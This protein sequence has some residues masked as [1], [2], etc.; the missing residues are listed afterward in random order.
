[1]MTPPQCKLWSFIFFYFL[2]SLL[3]AFYVSFP[4][5]REF[6]FSQQA[7]GGSS[8]AGRFWTRH[9]SAGGPAGLVWLVHGTW[10]YLFQFCFSALNQMELTVVYTSKY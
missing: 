1:M 2:L 4:E 3:S 7:E 8:Q 5:A 9:R 10:L 6:A